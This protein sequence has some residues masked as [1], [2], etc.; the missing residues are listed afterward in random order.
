VL[1]ALG[2]AATGL[3]SLEASTNSIQAALLVETERAA[4]GTSAP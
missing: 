2:T 1:T 3:A 4:N